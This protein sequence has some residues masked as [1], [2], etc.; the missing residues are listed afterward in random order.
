M[1]RQTQVISFNRGNQLPSPDSQT[2]PHD[3]H[4]TIS[5]DIQQDDC[6][7]QIISSELPKQ[8]LNHLSEST[9]FSEVNIDRNVYHKI[10]KERNKHKIFTNMADRTSSN[11]KHWYFIDSDGKLLG[12]STAENMD[13]FFIDGLL[14]ED[15]S[16]AQG[17]SEPENFFN[18]SVLLKKYFKRFVLGIEGDTEKFTHLDPVTVEHAD[19]KRRIEA[20]ERRKT[21]GCVVGIST[22]LFIK[23]LVTED[24]SFIIEV[25]EDADLESVMTT[26]PRSHTL[27]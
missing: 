14:T 1:D 18:F 13:R 27:N 26:R 7:H 25:E 20:K 8:K 22:T 15:S 2:E 24:L 4:A 12:P 10:L 11:Y 5:S 21:V 17:K 23:D 19:L 16:I 9:S 6:N 3:K